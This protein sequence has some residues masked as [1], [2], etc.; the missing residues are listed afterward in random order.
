ML[1]QILSTLALLYISTRSVLSL[2][3]YWKKQRMLGRSFYLLLTHRFRYLFMRHSSTTHPV[4]PTRT[5]LSYF[6]PSL[7]PVTSEFPVVE[8]AKLQQKSLAVRVRGK[9]LRVVYIGTFPNSCRFTMA[10]TLYP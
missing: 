4:L 5:P 10:H 7:C 9:R 8:D 2:S 6:L 1:K 3:E